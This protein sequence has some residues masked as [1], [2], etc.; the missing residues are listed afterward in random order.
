[1]P[2]KTENF[3]WQ[4]RGYSRFKVVST[5]NGQVISDATSP[6][7]ITRQHGFTSVTANNAN[8]RR[9]IHREPVL[10]GELHAT[11][12]QQKHTTPMVSFRGVVDTQSKVV[13]T[14]EDNPFGAFAPSVGGL[15]TS[16]RTVATNKA[17][18]IL[19]KR[20]HRATRAL[21]GLV[22]LG[23]LRET[24]ELLR[25]PYDGIYHLLQRHLSRQNQTLR[26]YKRGGLSLGKATDRITDEWLQFSFGVTPLISDA[27]DVAD[28]YNNNW[29]EP[30]MGFVPLSAQASAESA[31]PPIVLEAGFP[32]FWFLRHT[33]KVGQQVTIK[34]RSA[35][36]AHA[37]PGPAAAV[38]GAGVRD[39]VPAVW[40]LIPWSFFLDYF[41]NIGD[42]LDAWSYASVFAEGVQQT[43]IWERHSSSDGWTW[44]FRPPTIPSILTPVGGTIS[45][46][47]FQKVK[48]ID[49]IKL[50]ALP[51]PT[52]QVNTGL[53]SKRWANLLA[54]SKKSMPV[55]QR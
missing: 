16:L 41:L 35:Y 54:L 25:R 24:M 26:H 42:I 31:D 21:Q 13:R 30:K 38:L 55:F 28:F 9:R 34:L 2:T 6:V 43:T 12:S 52:L 22:F 17:I 51:I 15:D 3:T 39:F 36:A 10:T 48:T 19:L 40:E 44:D 14:T 27:N 20:Y 8:W 33:N 1:M 47:V 32:D 18:A 53:S 50:S 4:E 11:I 45:G 37:G 49:R 5:V 7:S 46:S 23:E 29:N